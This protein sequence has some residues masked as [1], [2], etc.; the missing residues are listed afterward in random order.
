MKRKVISHAVELA[1]A[2]LQLRD[3]NGER[4]VPHEH[5]KLMTAAQI[6]SLF[7][8]DHYPIRVAD[9]GANE[10]WNIEWRIRSE[11]KAK[12]AKID[13]PELAKQRRIR[14]REKDRK[15]RREINKP[16][17]RRNPVY[18]S[19]S[20]FRRLASRPFPKGRKFAARRKMR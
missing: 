5:A 14:E 12:T 16:A 6:I 11:H 10:P 4:Y 17:R 20:S 2:L 15:Q 7:Q 13:Q 8:R 9:G 18:A 1:A 3:D 19:V